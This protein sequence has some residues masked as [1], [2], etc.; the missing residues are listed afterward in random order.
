[1]NTPEH[2]LHDRINLVRLVRRLDKSVNQS[3]WGFERSTT[4]WLKSEGLLQV[5]PFLSHCLAVQ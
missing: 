4:P 2:I 1:M 5:R 3:D